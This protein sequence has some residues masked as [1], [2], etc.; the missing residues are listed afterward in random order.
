MEN[1]KAIKNAGGKVG[2]VVGA[3]YFANNTVNVNIRKP[4]SRPNSLKNG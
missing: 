3:G 4:T 1:Q 2:P